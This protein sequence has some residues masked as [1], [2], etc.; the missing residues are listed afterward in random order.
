MA[1][2]NCY[3]DAR[4]TDSII[5]PLACHSLMQTCMPSSCARVGRCYA[6]TMAVRMCSEWTGSE[7]QLLAL[8]GKHKV[9]TSHTLPLAYASQ[10][11]GSRVDKGPGATHLA[12]GAGAAP[13]VVACNVVGHPSPHLPVPAHGAATHSS[14]HGCVQ[15]GAEHRMPH[16]HVNEMGVSASSHVRDLLSDAR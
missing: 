14:H 4:V 7:Q 6:L 11:L 2:H 10:V 1:F 9:P 5:K 3:A 15:L 12:P 13:F 8:L 16:C